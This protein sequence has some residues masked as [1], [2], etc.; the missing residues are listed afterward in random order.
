MTPSRRPCTTARRALGMVAV[1]A[2]LLSCS[3]PPAAVTPDGWSRHEQGPASVAVPAG[4]VEVD[5][6]SETWPLA[7]ADDD[8]LEAAQY[9]LA[10]SPRLG[11]GGADLG[12]STFVTGGQ[13]GIP[14]YVS[15]GFSEPVHSD[16]LEIFRN[17]YTYGAGDQAVHGVFWAAADPQSGTTIGVQ[18]TGATLP[19]DLVTALEKSIQVLPG[20]ADSAAGR[21][22]G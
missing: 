20:E 17:D 3:S 5:G 6:S 21:S 15:T 10:V 4:W 1:G 11:T 7:W 22:T 13:I 9:A 16:T 2:L 19:E 18:L 8:D 14:G 12:R